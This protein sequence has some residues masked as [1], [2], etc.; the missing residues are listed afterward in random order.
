MLTCPEMWQLVGASRWVSTPSEHA[1]R[2]S[3]DDGVVGRTFL[4]S[5]ENPAGLSNRFNNDDDR[6][7]SCRHNRL[8]GCLFSLHEKKKLGV[9]KTQVL[10]EEAL[11]AV[12]HSNRHS[13]L[14]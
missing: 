8:A 3:D 4:P 2:I 7:A 12:T 6:H 13:T 14:S 10:K 1:A 11:V 9:L 5:R